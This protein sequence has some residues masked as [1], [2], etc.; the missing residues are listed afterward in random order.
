MAQATNL[1]ERV[2]LTRV[3]NLTGLLEVV[4]EIK[5]ILVKSDRVAVVSKIA[6]SEG[7]EA[8]LAEQMPTQAEDKSVRPTPRSI[9]FLV[10]DN[11]TNILNAELSGSQIHGMCH[12]VS[13]LS[14]WPQRLSTLFSQWNLLA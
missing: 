2:R 7:H 11:V 1:L 8:S 5:H 10:V 4:E 14:F 12:L 3:F 9:G 6:N 13:I